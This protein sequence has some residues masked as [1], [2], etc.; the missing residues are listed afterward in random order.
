[1]I[2]TSHIFYYYLYSLVFITLNYFIGHFIFWV[3]SLRISSKSGSIDILSKTLTGVISSVIVFS[4]IITKGISYSL[5]ALPIIIFLIYYLKNYSDLVQTK[6]P[7]FLNFQNL[8]LK[9]LLYIFASF[10]LLVIVRCISFINL[11]YDFLIGGGND[12]TYLFYTRISDYLLVTG[13]ENL[14][15]AA[16]L[17]DSSYNGS[18]IYHY[19]ELWLGSLHS[20]LFNSASSFS[21]KISIHT[22]FLTLIYC[23]YCALAEH[24]IGKLKYYH[25]LLILPFL[26]SSSIYSQFLL[27]LDQTLSSYSIYHF[28]YGNEAVA[29]LRHKIAIVELV[30]LS[31]ILLFLKKRIQ[32]AF[33]FLLY[34]ALSYTV[35]APATFSAIFIF[36]FAYLFIKNKINFLPKATLFLCCIVPLIIIGLSVLNKPNLDIALSKDDFSARIGIMYSLKTIG[37]FVTQQPLLYFPFSIF[38][39]VLFYYFRK[40]I[41]INLYFFL[42]LCLCGI[43]FGSLV[44]DFNWKQFYNGIAYPLSKIVFTFGCFVGAIYILEQRKNYNKIWIG[45]SLIILLTTSWLFFRTFR[46]IQLATH[47]PTLTHSID[48]LNEIHQNLDYQSINDPTIGVFL[49]ER[50][51]FEEDCKMSSGAYTHANMINAATL[52]AELKNTV[53]FFNLSWGDISIEKGNYLVQSFIEN[54][55]F[56]NFVQK[57]KQNNTFVSMEKSKVDFINKHKIRYLIAEKNVFL[58][59]SLEN[60]IIKRIIDSKTGLQF[61]VLKEGE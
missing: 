28:I 30:L 44:D 13:E 39:I 31:S 57:Q 34:F 51:K 55:I 46:N 7:S 29:F 47:T 12:S 2:P 33:C 4:L 24:F 61:C 22:L 53:D 8:S 35:I 17:L 23:G 21:F 43:L 38:F 1:M 56:M 36:C 16:N 32:I 54:S 49:L 50:K 52:L 40:K 19:F 37:V 26:F 15:T 11:D 58:S 41:D 45:F 27:S 25:Y 14:N 59:K 48:F 9:E 5:A 42:L 3:L 10:N 60:K 18:A 20:F 6:R